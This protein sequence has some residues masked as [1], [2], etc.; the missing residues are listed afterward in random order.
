MPDPEAAQI[1]MEE[2]RLIR[3]KLLRDRWGRLIIGQR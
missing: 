3:E 1:M 2:N